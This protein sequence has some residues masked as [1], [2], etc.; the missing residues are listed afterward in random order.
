[1]LYYERFRLMDAHGRWSLLLF[2]R[3]FLWLSSL[4]RI[5]STGLKGR[6]S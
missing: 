2:F 3:H 1:M 6:R 4:K 5:L